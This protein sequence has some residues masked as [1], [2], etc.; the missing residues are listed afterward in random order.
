MQMRAARYVIQPV[1]LILSYGDRLRNLARIGF[2]RRILCVVHRH[3]HPRYGFLRSVSACFCP[4]CSDSCSVPVLWIPVSHKIRVAQR[5][6]RSF[7][8]RIPIG[9]RV[10]RN[11]RAIR[12]SHFTKASIFFVS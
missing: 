10:F 8:A 7:G 6:A 12:A 9:P 11:L 1:I 3:L 5:C 4:S 2:A